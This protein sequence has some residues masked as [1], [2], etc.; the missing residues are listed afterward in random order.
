MESSHTF[1]TLLRALAPEVL[2]ALVRRWRDLP[3]CEDA[4]QEALI[5][6]ATQWATRGVPERPKGWLVHVA[7]RRLTDRV[8]ADAARRHREALVVAMI[9]SDEQVALAADEA[10]PERDDTLDLLFLCCHPELTSA[11]AIALTLRAVGGLTT[12]EIA[13]AFLVPEATIAQRISRAKQTIQRSGTPFQLPTEAE[14]AER[15]TSVMRV[16]Y[17]VFNEGYAASSGD[18]VSR[19]DLAEEATRMARLLLAHAPEEPEVIGLLALMRL[20]DARRAARTGASGELVPL[21]AQD[22]ARWDRAAIEEGLALVERAMRTGRPGAYSIQA[23]IAALHDEAASSETTDW[24]Q[25]LGLYDVLLHLERS[26]MAEL[27]RVVALAMVEGPH[28]GLAALRP[29]EGDA[30]L[31]HRLDAVRGHLLERAGDRGG[32]VAAYRRAAGATTSHAERDHLWLRA[33][34]LERER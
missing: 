8:R 22:R 2:G 5:E 7:T 9:P 4:V 1:Q 31:G 27:S 10:M 21:D 3:A 17:L 25:I 19:A 20:T 26:P 28:A 13:R 24:P 30:R 33:A 6:A 23:A 15:L 16:L 12:S 34:S 11:S 18:E 29:M 14:R 32:A